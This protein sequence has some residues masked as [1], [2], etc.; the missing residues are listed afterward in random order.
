MPLY[1]Y[2]GSADIDTGRNNMGDRYLEF[3]ASGLTSSD[4]GAPVLDELALVAGIDVLAAINAENGPYR[5]PTNEDIDLDGDGQITGSEN[6]DGLFSSELNVLATVCFARGT[7][8][9]TPQG[10]RLIET[11]QPG[12]LVNTL[13]AGPQA[14]RWIG[15]VNTPARGVNAPVHIRAGALGNTRDLRVSQNHRMLLTGP[16]AELL[17]GQPQV[18]VPAKFLVNDSTIRITPADAITY[19]HFLFD[20]HHIVFA[21]ACPAESLFPGKQTLD[22]LAPHE[23]D[24]ILDLFPNLD[25]SR[26]MGPT[27]RYTLKQH[28]ARA[29]LRSA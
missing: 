9:D 3:D 16:H 10:P 24:E 17:F 15:G 1:S 22:V 23:R 4:S 12:D 14:I 20:T 7:L 8:I 29:L 18:L 2:S 28:E 19:Y 11:L 13:D 25:S 5:V 26:C 21:E 27:S 6:S